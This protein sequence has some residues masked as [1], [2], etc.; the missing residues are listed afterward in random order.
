VVD[1]Q[2]GQVVPADLR[3]LT[4][5]GLECDESV[6]TAS[7]W[8]GLWFLYQPPPARYAGSPLP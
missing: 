8:L 7:I 4:G 5:A 1:L 2:L 6:L 3:L